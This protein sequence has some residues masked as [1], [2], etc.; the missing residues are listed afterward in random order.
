MNFGRIVGQSPA[1]KQM[2]SELE[3]VAHTPASVLVLGESGVGKELVA[4]AIHAQSPRADG[5]LVK[6]N[7]ASIPKE[8]FESEFFG[9]VKG[10]FKGGAS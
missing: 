5:P 9:H 2:L 7:C 8:L 3:A 10:A 4:R 1:L 6:V